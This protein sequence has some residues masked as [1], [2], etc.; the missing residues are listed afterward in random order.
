M[1]NYSLANTKFKK[2]IVTGGAGF[3][4]SHLVDALLEDGLEVISIDDYSAGKAENLEHLKDNV[5][6]KEVSCDVTNIE[7][8]RPHFEGVDIVFHQACSKNTICMK[9]PARD[10]EVNAKG[11]LNLLLL[12]HEFGVKKFIHASTGSVYG[13]AKYYPTDENHPLNPA[14]YYGVSKLA[15][16]KYVRAFSELY[17]MDSVILRYF[18]V[19][20]PRQE[21]SDVGGVVSIF[22]RRAIENKPLTIYGDGT[23]LRSFTYVHDVVR[24]NK[25]AALTDGISGEAFNCASGVKVTIQELADSVLEYFDKKDLGINYEDWKPGD[26]KKFDVDNSK[27]KSLGFEFQYEFKDGLER[28]MKWSEQYFANKVPAVQTA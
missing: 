13:N 7:A 18:H 2:A 19:F 23:Q 5:K 26:V 11:A 1:N 16:E 20:G 21:N 15:G 9:D 17:G 28:T 3:V 12:A 25:L 4:G 10:L 22:A 8:L 24:I 14:S 6:F 27:I